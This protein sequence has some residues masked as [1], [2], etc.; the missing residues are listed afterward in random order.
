MEDLTA[1]DT[2]D[3]ALNYG[4]V[5]DC[6]SS[7]SRVFVYFWPPHNGNPHDLLDIKQ[8]R[9]R[10]SRP[11]VKKI[12]PGWC[13]PSPLPAPKPPR[14]GWVP[15]LPVAGL[16][17]S[18]PPFPGQASPWRRQPRSKL[19]PT[20]ALCFSL[21]QPTS[22]LRSTRRLRF[23]SCARRACG[24]CPRGERLVRG[25]ARDP[26]G[27]PIRENYL[28]S[29]LVGELGIL[30]WGGDLRKEQ[31]ARAAEGGFEHAGREVRGDTLKSQT[32]RSSFSSPKHAGRSSKA[33]GAGHGVYRS[34]IPA[35]LCSRKG[36]SLVKVP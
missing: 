17:G 18:R 24:C 22:R 3:S 12:K 32:N 21:R 34:R 15:L 6:G 8:M 4:V 36:A 19:R 35:V 29:S 2:E 11:V 23:T 20:C 7:G 9:D 33:R 5:V 28:I 30:G 10:N 14:T 13:H 31:A 27:S 25:G 16:A 1:T 26:L